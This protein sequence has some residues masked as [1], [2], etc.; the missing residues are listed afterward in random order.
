MPRKYRAHTLGQAENV[1]RRAWWTHRL[2]LK[3][4]QE[5]VQPVKTVLWITPCDLQQQRYT[6]Q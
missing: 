5:I 2:A 4:G 3:E 6:N 1:S